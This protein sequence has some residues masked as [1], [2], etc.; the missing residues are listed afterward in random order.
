M[1]PSKKKTPKVIIS[2]GPKQLNKHDFVPRI[3]DI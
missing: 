3:L 1:F 2:K